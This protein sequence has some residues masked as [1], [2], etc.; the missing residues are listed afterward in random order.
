MEIVKVTI[1]PLGAVKIEA[2][3]FANNGCLA[4]TEPLRKALAGEQPAQ[5]QLKPEGYIEE[6][7]ANYEAS[8][9]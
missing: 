2:E 4:A 3:G 7:I 6:Q 5:V 1:S 9:E 8:Y